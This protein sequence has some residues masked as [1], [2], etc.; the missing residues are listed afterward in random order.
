V[1]CGTGRRF[2]RN[3]TPQEIQFQIDYILAEKDI[4]DVNS[5]S[6]KFQ[7]MFMSMGEPFLNMANVSDAITILA[8]K[9]GNAQLL[10]STVG[11]DFPDPWVVF[12]R[13][14]KAISRVGLQ[15]SLHS[16]FEQERDQI[17]PF[18]NKFSTLRRLRDAGTAWAKATGRKV[19]L[20]YCVTDT[21]ASDAL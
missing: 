5:R 4:R 11:I 12:M 13:T 6:E 15:F 7:I 9:Y 16:A 8:Q 17:I 20:N 19:Y 1:F 18:K 10:V 2:V 14:S 21:N 3:L